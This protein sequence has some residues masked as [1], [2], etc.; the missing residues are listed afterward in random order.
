VV[1]SGKSEAGGGNEAST[2]DGG[3]G[4]SSFEEGGG[5]L[6]SIRGFIFFFS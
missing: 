1:L 5:P 3:N 4:A 2:S 6:C